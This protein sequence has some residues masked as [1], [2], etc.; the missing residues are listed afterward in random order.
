MLNS[1][2]I[3]RNVKYLECIPDPET[4]SDS[5]SLTLDLTTKS[6]EIFKKLN[7]KFCLSV[8]FFTSRNLVG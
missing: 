7:L 4:D 3:S 1:E 5:A 2:Q 6:V 8:I